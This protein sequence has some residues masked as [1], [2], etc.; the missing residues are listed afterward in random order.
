[1]CLLPTYITDC[2]KVWE[3]LAALFR[4]N[5]YWPYLKSAQR[6]KDGRQGYVALESHYLGPNNIDN[7]ASSA[8][9]KLKNSWMFENFVQ[10]HVDHA[11]LA[12]LVDHGYSGMDE[13]SK[14]R[15]LMD[16]ICGFVP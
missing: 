11:I 6:S 7:M 1:M 5:P 3:L 10:V 9:C 12:G 8:K 15:H 16:G 14:V 4:E 2:R 13:W